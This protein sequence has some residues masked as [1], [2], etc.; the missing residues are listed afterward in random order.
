MSLLQCKSFLLP[1]DIRIA[2]FVGSLIGVGGLAA[3]SSFM[4]YLSVLPANDQGACT[5]VAFLFTTFTMWCAYSV[6]CNLKIINMRYEIVNNV[7]MNYYGKNSI[8]INL[9]SDFFKLDMVLPLMVVKSKYNIDYLLV[10]NQAYIV[11]PSNTKGGI[12]ALQNLWQLGIVVLPKAAEQFI[13]K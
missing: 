11:N 7:A 5:M 12:R 13:N 4:W 6:F 1:K 8:Q 2:F 9:N 3:F 10:T